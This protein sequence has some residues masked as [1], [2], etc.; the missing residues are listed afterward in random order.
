VL[1]NIG[2]RLRGVRFPITWQSAA[3]GDGAS[4]EPALSGTVPKV[5]C[6]TLSRALRGLY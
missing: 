3:L 6:A 2:V 5:T 4:V 1:G